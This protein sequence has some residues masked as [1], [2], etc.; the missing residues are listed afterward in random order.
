M[1]GLLLNS[2][3]LISILAFAQKKDT[4]RK[5]LDAN[6]FFTNRSNA[7]YPALA[8]RID[9]HWVLYATYPDTSMMLKVWFKDKNLTI[10]DG[11]YIL[12]FGKGK[13]S[14]E[15]YYVNNQ[16]AGSWKYWYRNGVLKDSGL[17]DHGQMVGTWSSKYENGKLRAMAEYSPAGSAIEQLLVSPKNS[18]PLLPS[19]DTLMGILHGNWISFYDNGNKLD[20]GKYI[21]GKRN[22]LW[23]SWY[24]NGETEA[25]G[26]LK[27]DSLEKEWIWYRQNGNLST[28]EFYEGNKLV[29]MEC[30]DEQGIYTGDYCSILKPPY[31]LGNF[32]D[33]ENF[34]MD[35]IMVPKTLQN[36]PLEGT[37][38]I[39]C[40]ITKD[41]KLAKL[42]VQSPYE[43]L[44]KEVERFFNSL[45]NW[46]PAIT[47]NR[48]IDYTIE[49][50]VPLQ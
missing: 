25:E 27:S 11:P 2:F 7:V 17:L 19:T 37:I 38:S 4:V 5:Y 42:I 13:K 35:N 34:M 31:P 22:G 28:K 8:I 16:G 50:K 26:Y 10:K 24:Q 48:T 40:D 30:F 39:K 32:R 44:T 29:K 43:T 6:L 9:D 14:I 18:S 1:R 23:K 12:N 21:N 41:G 47:H 33:F 36:K 45:T 46:S 49:Y 20:S 15:G 3:L